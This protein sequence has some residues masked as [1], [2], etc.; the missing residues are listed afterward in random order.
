MSIG[1]FTI[2]KLI[3]YNYGYLNKFDCC[4]GG[5]IIVNKLEWKAIKKYLLNPFTRA[6]YLWKDILK[7]D[8]ERKYKTKNGELVNIRVTAT[9]KVI[10]KFGIENG[11]YNYKRNNYMFLIEE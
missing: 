4:I 5:K 1:T 8:F 2:I 7:E 6:S 11:R 10:E 3:N 9:E